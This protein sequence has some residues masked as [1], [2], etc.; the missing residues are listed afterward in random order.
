DFRERKLILAPLPQ[1][2]AAPVTAADDD[3]PQDRYIA[4][5]MRSFTKVFILED[6]LFAP[7]VVN[8]KAVGNFMLDTGADI[9]TMSP[10]FAAQVTKASDDHEFTMKGV[11]G[12]VNQVLTGQ[13]AILQ[14]GKIR[15]ESHDLPVFSTKN[16]SDGFGIEIAGFIGIRSLSQMKMTID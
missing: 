10:T 9:N 3:S 2:P 11:S 13:K 1:N 16:Q 6:H 15:L 12:K 4:P 5:E 14:I 8:D 7:I